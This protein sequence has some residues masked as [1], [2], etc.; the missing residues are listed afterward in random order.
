MVTTYVDSSASRNCT[1]CHR[2]T[3]H[4]V[5]YGYKDGLYIAVPVCVECQDKIQFGVNQHM[6]ANLKQ[7]AATVSTAQTITGWISSKNPGEE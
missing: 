5:E 7:I 4:R 1:V 3:G 6:D 2:R